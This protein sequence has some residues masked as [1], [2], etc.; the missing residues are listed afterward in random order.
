MI[1][2][3]KSNFP[4]HTFDFLII[5]KLKVYNFFFF[6]VRTAWKAILTAMVMNS[7]VW[8]VWAA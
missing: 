5:T 3:F 4:L 7:S 1:V 2:G 8:A 6:A